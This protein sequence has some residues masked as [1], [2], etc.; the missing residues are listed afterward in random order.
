MLLWRLVARQLQDT[1]YSEA[2]NLFSGYT[3]IIANT[4]SIAN[5][6]RD[7][8]LIP[9]TTYYYRVYAINEAKQSLQPSNRVAASPVYGR[10]TNVRGSIASDYESVTISWEKPS[11]TGGRAV[12]GYVIRRSLDNRNFS[13][14]DSDTGVDRTHYTDDTINGNT[15]YYYAVAVIAGGITGPYSPSLRVSIPSRPPS[16]VTLVPGSVTDSTIALSWN[17]PA[18]DGGPPVTGYLL[19]RSRSTGF[20]DGSGNSE[21]HEEKRNNVAKTIS[22]NDIIE[23][24]LTV[25]QQ[26]AFVIDTLEVSVNITHPW[27]G[28][29]EIVLESPSGKVVTLKP[30]DLDDRADN[31]IETYRGDI[32]NVYIGDSSEGIWKLKIRDIHELADDGT[33]NSW[34]IKFIKATE[35]IT[36]IDVGNV[37][38]Y[39]DS[40][41]QQETVYFYRLRAV[42]AVGN[43]AFSNIVNRETAVPLFGDGHDGDL[44]IPANGRV[45]LAL[46]RQYRNITIEDGGILEILDA[47]I[48]CQNKYTQRGTGK[49]VVDKTGCAG[50]IGGTT[51]GGAGAPTLRWSS[52]SRSFDI[53]GNP[54]IQVAHTEAEECTT[55]HLIHIAQ[56]TLSIPQQFRLLFINQIRGS[57]GSDGTPASISGRGGRNAEDTCSAGR[58]QAERSG[59]GD[60]GTAAQGVN[61]VRGGGKFAIYVKT[62]DTVMTIE[63]KGNDGIDGNQGT[64][65]PGETAP[66]SRCSYR[67]TAGGDATVL[68]TMGS[69]G[70]TGGIVFVVYETIDSLIRIH[71]TF[72]SGLEGWEITETGNANITLVNTN[73]ALEQTVIGY[74]PEI[75][76]IA[77]TFDLAGRVRLRRYL[78]STGNTQ[79]TLI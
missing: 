71:D 35:P 43:S 30:A 49:I 31:V 56:N 11:D 66:G 12:T 79:E 3:D 14:I 73:N 53:F 28:D 57:R 19:Q 77:K 7:S 70:S 64:G 18:S 36:S 16:A 75:S 9:G 54:N 4:G 13:T 2:Q 10:S 40:G 24:S 34:G 21:V 74:S 25:S 47:L 63:A 45:T 76:K 42:N 32:F 38:S 8:G 51:M 37:T 69:K 48:Q 65:E 67:G 6:Y 22:G 58:R 1:A 50:G 26:N 20:P 52:S 33:L 5:E 44:T 41:L 60:G 29:M 23:D 55:D 15:I 39:I 68:G 59:G 78:V 61:G 46:N 17:T 72:D 27:R 62:I